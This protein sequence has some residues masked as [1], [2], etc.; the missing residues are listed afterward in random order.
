[1]AKAKKKPARRPSRNIAPPRAVPTPPPPGKGTVRDPALVLRMVNACE[2]AM[3]LRMSRDNVAKMLGQIAAGVKDGSAPPLPPRTVDDYYARVKKRW[4]DAAG[5]TS[6]EIKRQAVLRQFSHMRR[7]V[8]KGNL[9]A[10]ARHEK[11]LGDIQGTFAPL[12]VEASGP[13]GAPLAPRTESDVLGELR[14]LVDGLQAA[15][16]EPK[17][18]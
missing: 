5:E 4:E 11:L 7:A 1:M 16:A 6:K 15:L 13:N 9:A 10:V 8:E 18:G 14:K 2:E 17:A 3:L 12:K